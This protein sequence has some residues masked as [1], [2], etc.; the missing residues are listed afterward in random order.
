MCAPAP[1]AY[2]A[3]QRAATPALR[4]TRWGNVGYWHFCD[5]YRGL[6]QG[7]LPQLSGRVATAVA[8]TGVWPIAEVSLAT[9][10]PFRVAKNTSRKSIIALNRYR[11]RKSADRGQRDLE[12]STAI[13]CLRA[14][15]T[16]RVGERD[17]RRRE[18]RIIAIQGSALD[19]KGIP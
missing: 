14:G 15:K 13:F 8:R 12:F 4:T 19:C 9:D 2:F 1:R 10:E 11:G 16:L 18:L 3:G 17:H 7:R 6:N 5:L